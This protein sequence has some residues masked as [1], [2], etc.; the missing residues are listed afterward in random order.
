MA[1]LIRRSD[2]LK[3]IN[4]LEE[5]AREAGDDAA[6]EAIVQCW[7]AVMSCRVESRIFCNECRKRIKPEK[8][9]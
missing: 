9:H 1:T 3:A 8:D 5:K 4:H 7:H 6:A 2:A